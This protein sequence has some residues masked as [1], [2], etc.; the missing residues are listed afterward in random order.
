M[1]LTNNC[2][3]QTNKYTN[4]WYIEEEE[5]CKYMYVKHPDG[6]K[7]FFYISYTDG[8]YCFGLGIKED[9]TVMRCGRFQFM[10]DNGVLG[11]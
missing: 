7:L 8:K 3:E 6:R 1:Q 5:S 11:T 4:G 9:K 10:Y 2:S